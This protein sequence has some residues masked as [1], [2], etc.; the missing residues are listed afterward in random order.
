MRIIAPFL[1]M[2]ASMVTILA[3]FTRL[4]WSRPSTP[5]DSRLT[6]PEAPSWLATAAKWWLVT[7]VFIVTIGGLFFVFYVL[8]S[9]S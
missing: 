3:A 4:W 5:Q 1:G 7:V 9:L 2:V 8:F 6:A